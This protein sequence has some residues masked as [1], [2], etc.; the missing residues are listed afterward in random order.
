MGLAMKAKPPSPAAKLV[1]I[2]LVDCC[3]DE[4]RRIFPS[5]AT[6]ADVAMCS[7]RTVQRVLGD[8]CE[9]GLLRCVREGGLGKGSTNQ[10]EMDVAMLRRIAAKGWAEATGRAGGQDALADEEAECADDAACDDSRRHAENAEPETAE[11]VDKPVDGAGLRVTPCHPKEGLRVTSATAK[12]DMMCHPTP[13]YKPSREERE[14]AG[15]DVQAGANAGSVSHAAGD[16]LGDGVEHAPPLADF[17]KAWPSAAVD[18][19]ER[20]A[21]AWSELTSAQ[22][23]AA[24]AGIAGYLDKSKALGRKT[25]PAGQTYLGERRWTLLG[26]M[27]GKVSAD[28]LVTAKA[29]SRD[30]WA[31]FHAAL[32][33]KRRAMLAMAER[34]SGVTLKRGDLAQVVPEALIAVPA[35]GDVAKNWCS[36][37][38]RNGVRLP[39][40]GAEQWLF[41]PKQ[42]KL[43]E[44]AL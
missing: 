26:E 18:S 40:F 19:Q 36:A 21:A 4:G 16:G 42:A 38:E 33:H 5:V 43:E 9:A 17:V 29:W 1:L 3:D 8:F 44:G 31:L 15:A 39:R 23:R 30:W 32:P 27:S 7:K 14:S 20:I 6:L 10:Y 13:Q 2:K 37:S 11:A 34:G 35:Q 12:G 25:V 28:E 24:L 41:L 22:K